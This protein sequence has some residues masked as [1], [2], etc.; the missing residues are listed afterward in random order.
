[1]SINSTTEK[2]WL[3]PGETMSTASSRARSKPVPLT[4][5]QK[6]V[7]HAVLVSELDRVVGRDD[8]PQWWIPQLIEKIEDDRAYLTQFEAWGLRLLLAEYGETDDLPP[9][10]DTLATTIAD[11][12]DTTFGEPPSKL[13]LED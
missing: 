13:I 6:W 2:R 1:M 10:E 7:A 4:R 11:L 12:L 3:H 8:L 5:A 9:G